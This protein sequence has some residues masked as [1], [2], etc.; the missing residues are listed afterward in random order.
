[1]ALVAL[2]AGG[3]TAVAS[4]AP[5]T[6][7]PAAPSATPATGAALVNQSL[8]EMARLMARTVA[9][10]GLRQQIHDQIAK[11]DGRD[12]AVEYS[13][14]A[15]TSD[16]GTALADAYRQDV[17][18][19]GAEASG[20]I[21]RI[22]GGVPRL[23][24]SVPVKFEGWDP[25]RVTPLVGYGR[26][27]IDDTEIETITA[28]DAAGRAHELD[29][30]SAPTE[31]VIILG[32]NEAVEVD[33]MAVPDDNAIPDLEQQ[34]SAPSTSSCYNVK[35][36]YV[37]LWE[38]KEPWFKG[39]AETRLVA[40]GPGLWYH[41]EFH[42][43]EFDGDQ[44]W[45]DE[46]L[47]CA[48]GDVRFYWYENDSGDLEFELKCCNGYAFGIKLADEDDLIGGKQLDHSSFAGT[49]DKD[50]DFGELKMTTR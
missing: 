12:H 20:A 50:T 47:G 43:L 9:D 36:S 27:D 11:Q 44:I 16:L 21:D 40:K 1:M 38:N 45:P 8:D 19:A 49:T 18:T 34:A 41:D 42:Y 17:P 37:R 10:Q 13:T 3:S 25:A 30:Q 15:A 7:A 14:L 32:V 6:P 39:P 28:Y 2:A 5:S 48:D 24:V 31:P 26:V 33:D 35:I 22:A 46:H 4:E 23:A 29:A